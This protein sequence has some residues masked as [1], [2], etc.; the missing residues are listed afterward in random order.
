MVIV[1]EAAE[2]ATEAD[3]SVEEVLF[4]KLVVS[5]LAPLIPTCP[6]N[7]VVATDEP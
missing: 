5:V 6:V 4:K 1:F 3:Q 2:P 7:D